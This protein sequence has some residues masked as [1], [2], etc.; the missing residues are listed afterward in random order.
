MAGGGECTCGKEGENLGRVPNP[1]T[2][3]ITLL[4]GSP[5]SQKYREEA[6]GEE[7]GG[8]AVGGLSGRTSRR[9][10]K[11]EVRREHPHKGDVQ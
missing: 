10:S 4:E 3:P 2:T 9:E 1:P 6:D 7:G 8:P 11:S 5:A